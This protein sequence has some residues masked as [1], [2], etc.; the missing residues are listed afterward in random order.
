MV[1]WSIPSS[2]GPRTHEEKRAVQ[3]RA[4][5]LWLDCYSQRDIAEIIGREY[6]AFEGTTQHAVH[7]WLETKTASADLVSPPDSRQHF[8][9]RAVQDRAYD[10][11][12]DCY[13][14]RDIAEIIGRE[15]P[16][17]DGTT[18]QTLSNWL[19]KFS[20]DAEN[21]SPPD[22]RQHFDIWQFA[23]ADRAAMVVVRASAW[24]GRRSRRIFKA[25]LRDAVERW[26]KDALC[27]REACRAGSRL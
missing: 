6:P 12:L 23:T 25:H 20:A 11:W 16:A 19:N 24:D 9:K 8:G 4:Y 14:Q 13:S 7:K 15:Y 17:F 2:A 10:L 22:S 18:Q 27:R 1:V 3:D 5:D 21:L 26:T